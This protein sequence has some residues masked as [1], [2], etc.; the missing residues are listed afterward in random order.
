MDDER[1]VISTTIYSHIIANFSDQYEILSFYDDEEEI[2][3]M[4]YIEYFFKNNLKKF[5][6]YLYITSEQFNDIVVD[7][8]LENKKY[9]YTKLG[10]DI[11]ETLILLFVHHKR[12]FIDLD[13]KEHIRKR[14]I[15]FFKKHNINLIN[16]FSQF[17][18]DIVEFIYENRSFI[19]NNMK[20]VIK[21]KNLSIN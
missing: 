10:Y 15:Y 1:I 18:D 14:F 4:E 20:N 6:R 19:I 12:L 3:N 21:K 8:N 2:T 16:E 11:E 7:N 13:N 17:I 9:E 5:P